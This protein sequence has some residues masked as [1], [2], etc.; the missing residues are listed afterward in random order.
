MNKKQDEHLTGCSPPGE[1]KSPLAL[2]MQ[3]ERAAFD[4]YTRA[5]LNGNTQVGKH[6]ELKYAHSLRVLQNAGEI[7]AGEQVFRHDPQAERAL[8]MAALYH[9]L[10]RFEQLARYQTFRDADSVNHG[11]LGAKLLRDKRFLSAET[12]QLRHLVRAAVLWHNRLSLPQ[13]APEPLSPVS[14]ALRDAD[15]IDIIGILNEEFR[16]GHE[17]DKTVVLELRNDPQQYNHKAL[18]AVLDGRAVLYSDMESVNDFRLLLCSWIF[19][20]E[21][22][23]SLRLLA[24]SGHMENILEGLPS[25]PDMDK[26]RTRIRARLQES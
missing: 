14:K 8:L 2:A 1:E 22:G 25:G 12:P 7:A 4:A 18:E 15:K 13:G 19:M 16:P 9:D 11:L 21:F 23:S 10:G 17:P 26:V 20:L 3:R 6:L 24:R 5:F